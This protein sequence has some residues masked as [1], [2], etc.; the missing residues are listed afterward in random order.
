[1]FGS[2]VH[3]VESS[4]QFYLLKRCNDESPQKV[5][6]TLL[7]KTKT[8]YKHPQPLETKEQNTQAMQS[9]ESGMAAKVGKEEGAK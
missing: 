2:S 3:L 1:M 5:P 9:K 6:I 4:H 8:N 7:A